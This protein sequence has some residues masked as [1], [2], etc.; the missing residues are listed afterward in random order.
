MAYTA[1]HNIPGYLPESDVET[2]DTYR[3]AAD[4]LRQE[5]MRA[6]D[7]IA[8]VYGETSPLLFS[9]F[10]AYDALAGDDGNAFHIVPTSDSPHDLGIAYWVERSAAR[11]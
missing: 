3:D 6:A 10:D 1:G 5:M 4:W 11:P 7:G 2:F 8:D 9:Y